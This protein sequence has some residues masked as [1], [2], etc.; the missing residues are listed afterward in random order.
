MSEGCCLSGVRCVSVSQL[1]FSLGK[2]FR[3]YQRSL[4]DTAFIF[5][6]AEESAATSPRSSPLVSPFLRAPPSP[7]FQPTSPPESPVFHPLS[8]PQRPRA[9]TSPPTSPIRPAAPSALPSIAQTNNQAAAEPMEP[10]APPSSPSLLASLTPSLIHDS[11]SQLHLET[12]ATS[13][14]NV[15][16]QTEDLL[17]KFQPGLP[18]RVL[19]DPI[20]ECPELN[21]GMVPTVD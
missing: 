18:L 10:S 14:P 1:C 16:A 3:R 7:I 17:L 21:T 13:V 11:P 4:T 6:R 19:T 2:P 8:S 9:P 5:S 15:P 20:P 12:E